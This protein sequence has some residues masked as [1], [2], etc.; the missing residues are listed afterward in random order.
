M[1]KS[2][3]NGR[4]SVMFKNRSKSSWAEHEVCNGEMADGEK[5]AL[6]LKTMLEYRRPTKVSPWINGMI[7]LS[8]WE[9]SPCGME[10]R[11][12]QEKI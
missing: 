8:F 6:G 10:V 9:D 2:T 3:G 11:N 7:R 1:S 5:L 12:C 4:M